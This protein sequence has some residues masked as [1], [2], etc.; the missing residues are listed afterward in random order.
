MAKRRKL[1]RVGSRRISDAIGLPDDGRYIIVSHSSLMRSVCP[2]YTALYEMG[3]RRKPNAA[4]GIGLAWH[5]VM[6]EWGQWWANGGGTI[7]PEDL[8]VCPWCEGEPISD[9]LMDDEVHCTWCNDTKQGPLAR[10]HMA[11]IHTSPETADETTNKLRN[12]AVGYL[13]RWKQPCDDEKADKILFTEKSF[14]RQLVDPNGVPMRKQVTMIEL[15]DGAIRRTRFGDVNN[16]HIVKSW[17]E[18]WP[19]YL[20][21]IVDMAV[22][23]KNNTVWLIDSKSTAQPGDTERK[24]MLSSQ[25]PMYV[26]A[27]EPYVDAIAPGATIGGIMF[28][29]VSTTNHRDPK[30]DEWEPPKMDELKT[31][32]KERGIV[33]SKM[34]KDELVEALG[35]VPGPPKLNL[36]ASSLDNVPS[37]KLRA[38]IK[39]IGQDPKTFFEELTRAK[40]G[41]DRKLYKKIELPVNNMMFDRTARET[42]AR[43]LPFLTLQT[44]LRAATTDAEV[45]IVA[46]RNPVCTGPG[47]RCAF[48]SICPYEPSQVEALVSMPTSELTIERGAAAM[49][50][51]PED[52]A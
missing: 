37:W 47:N 20:L 45:D 23:R 50:I 18:V 19:V 49:F 29:V 11:W 13:H 30:I 21:V 40:E 6:E 14:A 46:P 38:A 51:E 33:A 4:Q 52:E 41:V 2:R 17:T 36:S 5:A 42:Y 25:L 26:W 22:L 9:D 48:E 31:M 1:V 3:L 27:F 43:A 44:E 39:G 12:I 8:D 16:P 24:L 15:D 7:V 28:D 34:K 35:I 32:A 10:Q